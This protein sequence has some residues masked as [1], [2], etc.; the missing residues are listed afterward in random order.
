MAQQVERERPHQ[1]VLLLHP[2]RP[3]V[4]QGL[5]LGVDVEVSRLLPQDDVRDES[6]AARY[7][8][9]QPRELVGQQ[10]E[11]AQSQAP[12]KHEHERRKDAPHAAPV[13][14][15][16][17]EAAA[18][19]V[20]EED[21]RDEEARDDEEHVDAGEA[22]GGRLWEG[23]ERHHREHREGAQAVDVRPIAVAA[24]GTFQAAGLSS[25]SPAAGSILAAA[26]S[27]TYYCQLLIRSSVRL[28]FD[29]ASTKR[30]A[31]WI[32]VMSG[33]PKSAALRRMR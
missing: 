8:L 21:A 11:P 33:M 13:E 30:C 18:L 5:Q 26:R 17:G 10:H 3:Q 2:E 23:V 16:E 7:V 9:A 15:G 25:F 20:L 22:A 4:K 27:S 32:L 31:S 6:G 12:Q 19:Q 28:F 14:P 1:V 24:H 29:T